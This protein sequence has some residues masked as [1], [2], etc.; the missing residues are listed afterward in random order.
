MLLSR[1][2]VASAMLLAMTNGAVSHAASSGEMRL[3]EMRVANFRLLDK[4]GIS[5]QWSPDGRRLLFLKAGSVWI[6]NADGKGKFR[7]LAGPVPENLFSWS[8]DGKRIAFVRCNGSNC[9]LM[10]YDLQKKKEYSLQDLREAPNGLAWTK[11]GNIVWQF[12]AITYGQVPAEVVG[13]NIDDLKPLTGSFQEDDKDGFPRIAAHAHSAHFGYRGFDGLPFALEISGD[14]MTLGGGPVW[15]RTQ[16]SSYALLVDQRNCDNA[17]L[18]PDSR[19]VALSR[20]VRLR[21]D[22]GGI[23]LA[24][25]KTGRAWN[26]W[27][28]LPGGSE[29]GLAVGS[30]L[31]VCR[32]KLNPLNGKVVGADTSVCGAMITARK[33][34]AEE[35]LVEVVKWDGTPLLTDGVV[36]LDE[37]DQSKVLLLGKPVKAEPDDGD[38]PAESVR[39]TWGP[40]ETPPDEPVSSL[41]PAQI[42][43]AYARHISSGSALMNARM[44]DAAL[45]EFS[46]AEAIAPSRPEAPFNSG[47]VLM[48][49]GNAEK[50]V[51]RFKGSI[52]RGANFPGPYFNLG[53]IY[54]KSA[55]YP[56][57]VAALEQ[58]LKISGDNPMIEGNL[59]IAYYLQGEKK[60]GNKLLKH[61]CKRDNKNACVALE[62]LNSSSGQ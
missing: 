60:K 38:I 21:G 41:D 50:A 9:S 10:V 35:S 56:E 22:S 55:R 7:L 5:P 27:Y 39:Q 61:S 37:N 49:T 62:K 46:R 25:L 16:D 32:K 17:A 54:L 34:E 29:Q 57:A 43:E 52:E 36:V 2:A 3:T 33:V 53:N 28:R 23:Y 8:Q 48:Y 18:S 45:K 19:T 47:M 11:E 4:D 31:R 24:D 6:V 13:L 58:A 15:A 26:K 59:G 14:W 1:Y 12:G 40:S 44:F 30:S 51:E 20:A 42:L